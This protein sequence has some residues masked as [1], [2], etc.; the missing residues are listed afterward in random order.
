MKS[1]KCLVI[2]NVSSKKFDP[3]LFWSKKIWAPR[4]FG[5]GKFLGPKNLGPKNLRP[6]KNCLVKIVSVTAA[7]FLIWINY[8]R[9]N[10]TWTNVIVTAY[11]YGPRNLPLKFDQNRI[12]NRWDIPN[13]DKWRKDKY[14]LDKCRCDSCNLF[15]MD[16]GTYL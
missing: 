6:P 2:Q 1:K 5:P 10:G 9:T 8:A 11:I 13:K 7:V 15:E 12:S 16:L 14:C 4:N 3:K